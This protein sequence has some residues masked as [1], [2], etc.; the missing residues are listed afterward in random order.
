MVEYVIHCAISY[1][2]ERNVRKLKPI[3]III[4]ATSSW[5]EIKITNSFILFEKT[6]DKNF[7]IFNGRYFG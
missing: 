6:W 3:Y 1:K 5:S 2:T 4:R 7:D